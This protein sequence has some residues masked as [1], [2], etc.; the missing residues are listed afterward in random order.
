MIIVGV[1]CVGKGCNTG[2]LVRGVRAYGIDTSDLRV[3]LPFSIG[4]RA[5]NEVNN[6]EMM[7]DRDNENV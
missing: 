5:S 6:Q 1:L 4:L 2:L 3:G 7:I